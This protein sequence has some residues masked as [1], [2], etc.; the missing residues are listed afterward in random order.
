MRDT[1]YDPKRGDLWMNARGVWKVHSASPTTVAIFRVFDPARGG[2]G[3]I[4][5]RRTRDFCRRFKFI[6]P[7]NA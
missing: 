6:K 5:T 2:R 7:G 4:E 3:Y 1:Y